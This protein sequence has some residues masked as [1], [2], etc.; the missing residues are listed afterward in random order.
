MIFIISPLLLLPLLPVLHRLFLTSAYELSGLTLI[1]GLIGMVSIL[2]NLLLTR[3]LQLAEDGSSIS[4]LATD[5]QTLV[6]GLTIFVGLW[7]AMT[8]H[9]GLTTKIFP[10]G[11]SVAAVVA[12]LTRIIIISNLVLG[13]FSSFPKIALSDLW[14]LGLVLWIA[15]H[16]IWAG[17]L[18]IWLLSSKRKFLLG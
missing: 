14:N 17:W 6:V 16:V 7:I 11:L 15:S 1:A 8:G 18:G 10:E 3:I 9:A 13:S 4:A 5:L 12:G 2:V